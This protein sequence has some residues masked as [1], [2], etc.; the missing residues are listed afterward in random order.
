MIDAK[1]M[2]NEIKLSDIVITDPIDIAWL[3]QEIAGAL[4]SGADLYKSE[5]GESRKARRPNPRFEERVVWIDRETFIPLRTEH[6]LNGRRVL[7]A[8]TVEIRSVQGV[9]TPVR[10]HFER[11]L[12]GTQVELVVE[13]VDYERPIPEDVFSVFNLTKSSRSER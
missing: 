8:E 2:G 12:D 6:Q 1:N 7:T 5:S 10:M 11:P 13:A 4:A 3:E 9:P